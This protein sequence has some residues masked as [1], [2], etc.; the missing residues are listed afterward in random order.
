MNIVVEP[1]GAAQ[2]I[3]MI[4]A[5][6]EIGRMAKKRLEEDVVQREAQSKDGARKL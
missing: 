1:E 6:S 2:V 3:Q 4:P 5:N